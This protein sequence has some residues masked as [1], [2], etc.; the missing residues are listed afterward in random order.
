MKNEGYERL[1]SELSQPEKYS[2]YDLFRI[3]D[4][5]NGLAVYDLHDRDLLAEVEKFIAQKEE[6]PEDAGRTGYQPEQ[7]GYKPDKI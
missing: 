6:Y 3:R 7:E 4:L 5:L 2:L 1:L